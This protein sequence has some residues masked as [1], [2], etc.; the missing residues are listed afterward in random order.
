VK[1]YCRIGSAFISTKV[2][3]YRIEVYFK[4]IVFDAAGNSEGILAKLEKKYAPP[5]MTGDAVVQSKQYGQ[6]V[7]WNH[8]SFRWNFDNNFSSILLMSSNKHKRAHIQLQIN[9]YKNMVKDD[10]KDYL[11]KK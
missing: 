1:I 3:S 8:E 4:G 9:N 5:H 2:H 7:P 6:W 11:S 10:V